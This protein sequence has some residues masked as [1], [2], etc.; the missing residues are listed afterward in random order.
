MLRTWG[1]KS[2]SNSINEAGRRL[3]TV[4]GSD[5]DKTGDPDKPDTA[6]EGGDALSTT[7]MIRRKKLKSK[8]PRSRED[9]EGP[10]NEELKAL[11]AHILSL[12]K[13]GRSS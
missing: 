4:D 12:T 3:L 9:S 10:V 8:D 13:A 11:E 1:Q 2:L 6:A 5:K 7:S